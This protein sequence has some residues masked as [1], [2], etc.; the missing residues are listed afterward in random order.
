[1]SAHDVAVLAERV[2]AVERH[3]ARIASKLPASAASVTH[4]G[5]RTSRNASLWRK[6][7]KSGASSIMGKTVGAWRIEVHDRPTVSGGVGQTRGQ[8]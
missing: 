8:P 1:M 4:G 5:T 6:P 3:L 2:S 7:A